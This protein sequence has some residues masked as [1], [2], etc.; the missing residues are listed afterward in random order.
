[1]SDTGMPPGWWQD[2]K[3]A[4]HAPSDPRVQHEPDHSMSAAVRASPPEDRSTENP[5]STGSSSEDETGQ[6]ERHLAAP[7][8]DEIPAGELC[9]NGHPVEEDDTFCKACGVAVQSASCLNGHQLDADAH[10]CKECGAPRS[11]SVPAATAQTS[12]QDPQ[13]PRASSNAV[14]ASVPPKKRGLHVL[15]VVLL[16]LV[17]VAGGIFLAVNR[18][19]GGGSGAGRVTQTHTITGT[20]TLGDGSDPNS[21]NFYSKGSGNCSGQS[22]YDDITQGAQV[23]VTD[24]GGNVLATSS[25]GL[26]DQIG[27]GFGSC[28]FSFTLTGVPDAAF[29]GVTISDR[30]TLNYSRAQMES[31]GW[32]VAM[33]LGSSSG[34]SGNTGNS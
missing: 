33:T 12:P 21:N 29:Y 4:W 13:E 22:G 2:R 34:N 18:S 31:A 7:S 5:T 16:I 3:G 27:S 32:S 1:M 14:P 11:P 26:G 8:D 28:R 25:L 30:G 24:G 10:F 15:V 6:A 23:T 19:S 9:P 17:V 20:L